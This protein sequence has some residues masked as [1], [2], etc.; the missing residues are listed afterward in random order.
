MSGFHIGFADF[1]RT[2]L[3]DST[4][5]RVRLEELCLFLRTTIVVMGTNQL[6][7]GV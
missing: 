2:M 4:G 7:A 3:L 6:Q 5:N 1:G